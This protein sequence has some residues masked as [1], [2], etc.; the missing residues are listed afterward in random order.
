MIGDAGYEIR[1]VKML[2]VMLEARHFIE[3]CDL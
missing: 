3:K 2:D 1:D